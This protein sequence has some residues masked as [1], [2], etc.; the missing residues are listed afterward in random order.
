MKRAV[1]I[2]IHLGSNFGSILQTVASASVLRKMSCEIEV[3]NYIPDRCTW[4]RFFRNSFGKWWSFARHLFIGFPIIALNKHIY[5]SYLRKYV[6]VSNPIYTSDDFIAVCPKADIYVTGSDQVWNSIHNE[7]LDK[8][9]YFDGFPEGTIKIAYSSSIGRESLDEWEYNEVKRM[10]GTYKAISV[11]EASAKILIESMGYKATHLLDPTFMLDRNDWKKYMGKRKI[12]HPYVL[13]Y[14]PYNIHD[15][16]LIYQ[17]VR[18]LAAVK[19]LNIVAFSWG[20]RPE[21]FADKTIFFANPGDFLSLMFHADY[22][23]TNS[24]HGTA[25]S[26]NLN[27]QFWVYMPTGFGTRIQSILDLC[28][29]QSRLLQPD[30]VINNDKMV[31]VIDYAPVNSILGN[32]RRKA[33]DFLKKALEV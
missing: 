17:S 14:L 33:Y 5:N 3:V 30:E 12:S 11:R 28:S 32:E 29:L 2:T 7:G 31:Q 19:N 25:F 8:H 23:V 16:G 20:I 27:K 13:V 15:K 18:K 10:L 22:V 9:Y 21:K 6:A 26:V 24:F 4:K 1:L